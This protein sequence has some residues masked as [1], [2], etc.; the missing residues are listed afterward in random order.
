MFTEKNEGCNHMKCAECK[1]E[2]CWLCEQQYNYDHYKSG[3][4]DGLQFFKAENEEQI[5]KV[6]ADPN[7][8][9]RDKYNPYLNDYRYNRPVHNVPERPRPLNNRLN[10]FRDPENIEINYENFQRKINCF[11]EFLFYF[12]LSPFTI[13]INYYDKVSYEMIQ[14]NKSIFF[15]DLMVA[16]NLVFLLLYYIIYLYI[17]LFIH[18]S[19]I[20]HKIIIIS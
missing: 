3:V 11:F 7:D 9:N 12:F 20:I 6:L 4:C 16:L 19:I 13:Y 10:N 17:T 8:K 5:K 14:N 18:I 15:I 1:Y 2:W